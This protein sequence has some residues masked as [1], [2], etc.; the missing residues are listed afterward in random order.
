MMSLAAST[1]ATILDDILLLRFKKKLNEA[2]AL[3]ESPEC[4]DSAHF[5]I[6]EIDPSLK[7]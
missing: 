2:S 7:R 5:T 4:A 1:L 6:S 3:L